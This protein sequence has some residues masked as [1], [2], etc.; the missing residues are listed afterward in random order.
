MLDSDGF[1]SEQQDRL[2]A[3]RGNVVLNL[4]AM[5]KALGGGWQ[6]RLGDDFVPMEIQ[7]EMGER[8]DWGNLLNTGEQRSWW[9]TPDW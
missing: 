8:T 9:R 3:T 4:V 6:R 5:Y 2:T 1:L 7:Q